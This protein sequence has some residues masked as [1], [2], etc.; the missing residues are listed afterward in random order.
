MSIVNIFC[1]YKQNIFLIKVYPSINYELFIYNIK[2]SYMKYEFKNNALFLSKY[3]FIR[4]SLMI[5]DLIWLKL[6]RLL[7]QILIILYIK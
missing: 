3:N 6:D 1:F 5:F 4:K 2:I 7:Y